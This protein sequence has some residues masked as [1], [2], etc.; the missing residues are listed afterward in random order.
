M[1]DKIGRYEIIEEI[2]R[3]GMA[4]VF[5][6][7]DPR[8][9]REV[10][11][12]VLP[13]QFLHDP[14]F[15]ARFEREA[16]TLAAIEHPAIVPVYDYG[17]EAGQ[18]YLVMR[19]MQGGSLSDQLRKG[20]LTLQESSR[21]LAR[22]APALDEMHARGII[23]RDLKPGNILFDQYHNAFIT[24]FG[25]ARLAEATTTLTGDSI[26][27]TPAYMSPEQA[28]GD[29]DIDGRSDIYA[30]GAILFE[31][32]TGKQPYQAT[33]PM[34]IVM[35]HITEPVPRIREVNADLPPACDLLIDRAMAKDRT[36]RFQT[37]GELVSAQEAILE[38]KPSLVSPSP[39]VQ[40]K[41]QPVPSSSLSTSARPV[42]HTPTP[43]E[44]PSPDIKKGRK[45]RPLYWVIVAASLVFIGVI[46]LAGGAFGL[47]GIWNPFVIGSTATPT[48]EVIVSGMEED[49][50]ESSPVRE[51]DRFED[52]F[53]DPTSGWETRVDHDVITDY[54]HGGFRI[55]V[56]KAHTFYWSKPGLLYTDVLIQ[57]DATKVAGP[58][59]NFFGVICRYQ[60]M[61]NFYLLTISSDGY[62]AIWKYEDGE[63][64]I[65]GQDRPLFSDA[66]HRG[67][68]T[69]LV[70]GE[71][72]GD[73]LSL[74]A[75]DI[76]LLLAE[77]SDFTSGDVG[78]VAAALDLPG[79]DIL[80]DNFVAEKP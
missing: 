4:T 14:T 53:T 11:L 28:R 52:I 79:T 23:H 38:G 42:L 39:P 71:C 74:Y 50:Q 40:E 66:V 27:G 8:F 78:L 65:L 41:P 58:D 7:Y 31:M 57:V 9:K 29:S 43:L 72:V 35:K 26:V 76:R 59:D 5:K 12:K 73:R 48:T 36:Q 80:F 33:T 19:Y 24:D 1:P 61:N 2:G 54:F 75:N 13:P 56:N 25:I 51:V 49:V 60:D 68:T 47:R 22:L 34:G 20:A 63:M 45:I 44:K 15:R 30:L 64:A 18:P 77:D 3:G 21:I 46:C 16:Q 69:N 6:A 55:F 37:V 10:A 32:L 62:Y 17:D 70:R 67:K